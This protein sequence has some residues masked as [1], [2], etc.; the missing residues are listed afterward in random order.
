MSRSWASR[1]ANVAG[2]H[3]LLAELLEARLERLAVNRVLVDVWPDRDAAA[4]SGGCVHSFNASRERRQAV[5]HA[6]RA[7]ERGRGTVRAT[8]WTCRLTRG[9]VTAQCAESQFGWRGT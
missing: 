9:G 2:T 4:R 3:K 5:S 6:R 1:D 8:R 7:V